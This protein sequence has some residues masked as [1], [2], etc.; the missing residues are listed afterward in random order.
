MRQHSNA[1]RLRVCSVFGN[2]V[3]TGLDTKED[4][5]V[6]FFP[7][8][9][10]ISKDFLAYTDSFEDKTLNKNPEKKGY[11]NKHG[12][13]RAIS[14]RGE[15][16]EG[17]IV[18]FKDLVAFCNDVLGRKLNFADCLIGQDF[19]TIFDHVLCQKYV[20]AT[21][22]KGEPGK[23][24]KG[25]T[26]KYETKLVDGQFNFHYDT[27]QLKRNMH[28]I[29]PDDVVSITNK[30]HGTSFVVSNVLVKK[31]LNFVLKL[32]SKV[33]PIVDT[34]YGILYSSRKVIKNRNF[35]MEGDNG[36]FYKEDVWKLVADK[37]QPMLK[38]GISVYGEIVGYSPS[39][40]WLQKDYDYGCNVG[41]YD[42][43]VYRV[44]YTSPAGDV[45]EFSDRQVKEWCAKNGVK[46]VPPYYYGTLKDMFPDVDV[47]EHWHD[48]VLERLIEQY[49]EKDCDLCKS[50]TV[51]AEGV[52]IR[53]DNVHDFEAFKLKSFRFLK[54][55]TEDLDAGIV[56]LE[57]EQS[58]TELNSDEENV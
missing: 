48:T 15:K 46:M 6:V 11:F 43:Y 38:A 57:T 31:K 3:I 8:E 7:V 24:K 27:L 29:S 58:M 19:D 22:P 42:Y 23:K 49:L 35:L 28:K 21:N 52:V 55:E 14:L 33:L 39:G 44:T 20:P 41:E 10:A 45:F 32:L 12:R 13:V 25:S 2:N 18:P 26:K 30:L 4:D 50:K 53:K 36:G 5:V 56:D 17:Y 1:D 9:S 54:K 34:E 51:P 16:S 37:L 47:S 40:K